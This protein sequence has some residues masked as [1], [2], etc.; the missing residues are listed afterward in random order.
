MSQI[1]WVACER[2]VGSLASKFHQDGLEL[3]DIKQE[4]RLAVLEHHASY[5]PEM[6]VSYNTFIGRRIRDAVRSFVAANSDM[7]EV[8]REWVADSIADGAGDAVRA[9][10]KAECEALRTARG[11]DLFK[12]PRRVI[13]TVR[14]TFSLD[15]DVGGSSGEDVVITRHEVIAVFAPE[16]EGVFELKRVEEAMREDAGAKRKAGRPLAEGWQFIV[17]ERAKGT[18]FADI[19]KATGRTV[20]AVKRTYNSAQKRLSKTAA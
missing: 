8:S 17:E 10:T 3:D 1:D 14:A 19:A 2:L 7:V 18:S 9:K 4:A 20:P 5:S 11:A 16:Q 12:K 15:E 6:G 13:E